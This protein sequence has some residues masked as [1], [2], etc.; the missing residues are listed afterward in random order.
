[1]EGSFGE[2]GLVTNTKEARATP[3]NRKTED[4]SSARDG[5]PRVLAGN[6]STRVTARVRNPVCLLPPA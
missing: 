1:V 5:S 2:L 3:N 6:I 4:P